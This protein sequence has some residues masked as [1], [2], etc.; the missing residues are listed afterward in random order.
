[1][2]KQTKII[3]SVIVI[4]VLILGGLMA[5]ETG[6]FQGYIKK[7]PVKIQIEKVSKK[8]VV[9][10]NI[11]SSYVKNLFSRFDLVE[12][13]RLYENNVPTSYVKSMPSKFNSVEIVRLYESGVPAEYVKAVVDDNCGSDEI[14][15]A[16]KHGMVAK[17]LTCD[18]GAVTDAV[19]VS[20][21][22][23]DGNNAPTPPRRR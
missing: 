9:E 17:N 13:E 18:D 1:M 3:I 4:G 2:K 21:E 20:A 5:S 10:S 7:T 23:Y 19:V 8:K 14:I 11:P 16:Y 12:I 15:F 6:L 22:K